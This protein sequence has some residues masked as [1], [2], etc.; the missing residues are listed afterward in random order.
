MNQHDVL[1]Y[2][3]LLPICLY[4]ISL[5]S[6]IDLP[7]LAASTLPPA[8]VLWRAVVPLPEPSSLSSRSTDSVAS[9]LG[10]SA[11]HHWP[12]MI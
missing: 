7:W 6:G 10:G 8:K 12:A 11:T 1:S 5:P 4:P 9:A 2:P 3:T